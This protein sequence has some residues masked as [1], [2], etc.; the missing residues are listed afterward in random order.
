VLF[1]FDIGNHCILGITVCEEKKYMSSEKKTYSVSGL[2]YTLPQ[3]LWVIALI[4]IGQ[5]AMAICIN[6]VP[7]IVPLKLKELGIS[8]TLLV[9]IMATLGQILNMTLCPMVSFKSDRYRSKRWGRRVPFILFTLPPLCLSWAM[10]AMYKYEAALL[11]KLLAPLAEL[12][13]TT[14]AVIVL[15]IGV[16]VFKF[17][18]MFVGSV[19]YYIPN[20][21][22]PAQFL[23]RFYGAIQLINAGSAALFN[24]FFF[25]YALSHFAELMWGTIIVYVI[26]MGAFCLLIKEPRFPDPTEQEKKQNSG[27]LA[28]VTFARESFSHPLYWYEFLKTACTGIAG[29]IAIFIVFFEQSMGLS[30]AEIGE[31]GGISGMLMTIIGFGIATV[32]TYIV[33]RWHPVRVAVFMSMFGMIIF[34]YECKWIFFQPGAKVFWWS[35]LLVA[36]VMFLQRFAGP[37]NMPTMMRLL[38]KSRFGSFCAARSLFGSISGLV[39]ALVLGLIIDFLR[40]NLG[41]GDRAYRYIFLWRTIF[42]GLSVFCYLMI[43]YHYCKLGGFTN[44]HAPA[45]WEKSGFEKMEVSPAL[46]SNPRILSWVMWGFDVVFVLNILVNFGWSFYAAGIGAA[47]EQSGYLFKAVPAAAA[48]FVFYL[49]VRIKIARL[50]YCRKR[51]DAEVHLPHHG[52][53]LMVLMMRILMFGALGVQAYLAISKESNGV[54]AGMSMF[55]AIIDCVLITM[56][57]IFVKM[58]TGKF[59]HTRVEYDDDKT[60]VTAQA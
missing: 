6:M 4:L 24:Y 36:Q 22:I 44:Y 5:F 18:Y 46:P 35:W 28:L 13:Q 1:I 41:M 34:F 60:D 3:L 39:F 20:D 42:Y 40:V 54:A 49:T 12:S 52:I 45:P 14:L 11:G 48:A 29:T 17:F 2:S 9:F 26:C 50:L 23:T 38:P 31:L 21:V 37:A 51:G 15:A 59:A 56:M 57:W 27:V 58:E 7:R 33:D 16:V 55:E 19:W 47:A 53:L 25:Q 30:L 32:G 43:Y 10:L 8:S